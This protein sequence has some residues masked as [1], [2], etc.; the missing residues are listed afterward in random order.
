MR[1]VKLGLISFVFLFLLVTLISLSIPS[2]IRISRATNLLNRRDSVFALIKNE[3]P[4]HPAYA[5]SASFL[6]MNKLRKVVIEQTDSTLVYTLQ[7]D[8]KKPV[9]SGWQLYGAPS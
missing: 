4:W 1:I 7:Q 5:D 2:H 9:T 8:D 6:Q 3:A